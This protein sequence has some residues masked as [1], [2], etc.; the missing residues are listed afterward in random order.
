M[1]PVRSCLLVSRFTPVERV[2]AALGAEPGGLCVGALVLFAAALLAPSAAAQTGAPR[3]RPKAPTAPS[4]PAKPAV[5][6]ATREDTALLVATLEVALGD[7]PK[8]ELGAARKKLEAALAKNKKASASS[9][10]GALR[11]LAVVLADDG[12]EKDAIKRFGEVLKLDSDADLG[13]YDSKLRTPASERAYDEARSKAKLPPKPRPEPPPP[14]DRAVIAAAEAPITPLTSAGGGTF[15]QGFGIVAG[16]LPSTIPASTKTSLTVPSTRPAVTN[17][18]SFSFGLG[19]LILRPTIDTGAATAT[20][21]GGEQPTPGLAETTAPRVD[22]ALYTNPRFETARWL[23]PAIGVELGFAQ[24]SEATKSYLL[25]GGDQRF[26]FVATRAKAKLGLGIGP[27]S[28]TPHGGVFYDYYAPEDTVPG[29]DKTASALAGVLYGGTAAI[30]GGGWSASIG[31][32]F[33]KGPD[34]TARR[35][36]LQIGLPGEMDIFWE[37]REVVSGTFDLASKNGKYSDI[38]AASM[39]VKHHYGVMFTW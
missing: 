14:P 10:V 22:F 15:T 34:Q 19:Y 30:G 31:Y 33:E 8:G 5:D 36:R 9:K 17:R 21:P 20:S 25:P 35:R 23:R 24:P 38:L 26:W 3:P 2:R 28:L 11:M 29:D 13:D 18:V 37:T 7:R 12:K 39:P 4:T 6:A 16:P 1:R 32:T 27:L